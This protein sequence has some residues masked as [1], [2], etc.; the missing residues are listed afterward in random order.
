MGPEGEPHRTLH[1]AQSPSL[2]MGKQAQEGR[3]PP[4]GFSVVLEYQ[5]GGGNC[6]LTPQAHT[7]HYVAIS[8]DYLSFNCI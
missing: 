1:P 7:V 6:S 2:W 3:S 8:Y 5:I 4:H